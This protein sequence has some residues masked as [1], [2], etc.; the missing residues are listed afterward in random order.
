MAYANQSS[1]RQTSQQQL[2]V[3]IYWDFQN[4]YLSQEQARLLLAF[5]IT[6]GSLISRRVYYNSLF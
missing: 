4:V 6:K 3:G 1:N 5:A 2:K